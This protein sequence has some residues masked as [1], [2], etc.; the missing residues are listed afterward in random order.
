MVMGNVKKIG[1]LV[2]RLPSDETL[3]EL[4]SNF[5]K[6]LPYLPMLNQL[7]NNGSLNT[8]S[9][10]VQKLPDKDVIESLVRPYPIW[11]SSLT[12]QP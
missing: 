1:E 5:V 8:L 2:G 7:A 6:L 10:L 4:N 9:T 11:I 12:P 3:K